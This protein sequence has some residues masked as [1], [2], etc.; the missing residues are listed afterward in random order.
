MVSRL[1]S[2]TGAVQITIFNIDWKVYF[3]AVY[4][5]NGSKMNLAQNWAIK[6]STKYLEMSRLQMKR[7]FSYL[8]Q[9]L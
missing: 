4:F 9:R 1:K 7:R 5:Y 6:L 8:L 2:S 3:K